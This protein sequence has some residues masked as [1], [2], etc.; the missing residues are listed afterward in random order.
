MPR[1]YPGIF[2]VCFFFQ[3]SYLLL[4][5]IQMKHTETVSVPN[6]EIKKKM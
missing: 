2:G 1:P 5:R 6:I 4:L 3:Y